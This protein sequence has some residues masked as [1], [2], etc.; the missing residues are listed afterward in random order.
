MVKRRVHSA[1][2]RNENRKC[3]HQG[4]YE[5]HSRMH[6][7]EYDSGS[8]FRHSCTIKYCY[9]THVVTGSS[10]LSYTHHCTCQHALTV[11]TLICS[12]RRP[13]QVHQKVSS[14]QMSAKCSRSVEAPAW[15]CSEHP[16]RSIHVHISAV[17]PRAQ[18]YSVSTLS[19]QWCKCSKG[20]PYGWPSIALARASVTEYF[21]S[22]L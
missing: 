4:I 18:S 15:R 19:E 21:G 13:L 3:G 17:Q 9:I 16:S 5:V 20:K 8:G 6:M 10:L 1:P 14:R 22:K 11:L 7:L 12:S 2:E